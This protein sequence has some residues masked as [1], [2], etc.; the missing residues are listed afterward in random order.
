MQY[1]QKIFS[2]IAK[3]DF[4]QNFLYVSNT[5]FTAPD[6]L[7][8]LLFNL[9]LYLFIFT[10]KNT[11]KTHPIFSLT[12]SLIFIHSSVYSIHTAAR[13]YADF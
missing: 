11:Y 13:F 6:Q 7:D 1:V 4:S 3:L 12:D 9:I 2:G 5:I 10:V 8:Q